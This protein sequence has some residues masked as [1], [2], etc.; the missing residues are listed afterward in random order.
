MSATSTANSTTELTSVPVTTFSWCT[1]GDA[2]YENRHLLAKTH[3]TSVQPGSAVAISYAIGDFDRQ[4]H[5]F[6]HHEASKDGE[7]HPLQLTFGGEWVL[8]GVA[9]AFVDLSEQHGAM[10]FDQLSIP[11]DSTLIP[12]HLQNIPK[13]Y[14]TF[15]VVILQPYEPCPCLAAAVAAYEADDPEYLDKEH[16]DLSVFGIQ[17][18]CMN[19]IPMSAYFYR[20]W[21]R[22]EFLYA[23]TLSFHSCGPPGG[24]CAKSSDYDW[25]INRRKLD[26]VQLTFMS[27]WCRWLYKEQESKAA[28]HGV[29][30]EETCR[31]ETLR[32]LGAG[33]QNAMSS[34]LVGSY[35]Q[36]IDAGEKENIRAGYVFAQCLLGKK[37]IRN[38]QTEDTGLAIFSRMSHY[39]SVVRDFVLG[40][41]PAYGAYTIPLGAAHWTIDALL[42]DALSQYERNN[43]VFISSTTPCGLFQFPASQPRSLQS[44]A[45]CIPSLFIPG[46]E[47]IVTKRDFYGSFRAPLLIRNSRYVLLQ[48]FSSECPPKRSRMTDSVTYSTAFPSNE[49][50][51]STRSQQ[52]LRRVSAFVE[53]T[54]GPL[55]SPIRCHYGP[56]LS[57]AA[58]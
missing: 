20:L 52:F 31:L 49:D 9:K 24:R 28:V 4:L 37:L 26:P 40:I 42:D 29:L 12:I 39:A 34:V 47:H 11:Q 30:Q 36:D 7:V 1:C 19:A 41:F 13:I 25:T 14:R 53:N 16:G 15:E 56:K 32:Y 44:S 48:Y 27:S 50:N 54:F 18:L 57:S 23:R 17:Q 45:R 10:W 3:P 21:T 22:Q 5:T 43:G 58:N 8:D 38:S 55:S 35:Q 51:S 46:A 2:Q 33:L 6:G